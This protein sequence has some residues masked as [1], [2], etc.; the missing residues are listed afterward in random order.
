MLNDLSVGLSTAKITNTLVNLTK[1]IE[2]KLGAQWE[3]FSDMNMIFKNDPA[4]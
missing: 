4:Y 2:I 3:E 1:E